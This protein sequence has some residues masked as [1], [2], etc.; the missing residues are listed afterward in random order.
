[1]NAQ[2]YYDFL[3][4][5][6]GTMNPHYMVVLHQVP[7]ISAQDAISY[8][9]TRWPTARPEDHLITSDKI[10]AGLLATNLLPEM[11]MLLYK[12]E[13]MLEKARAEADRICKEIEEQPNDLLGKVK[14][15]VLREEL[16]RQTGES[17]A[18]HDVWQM[19]HSRKYELMRLSKGGAV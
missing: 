19:L 3:R 5:I 14:R 15:S 18:L 1:M 8:V 9:M 2:S 12:I 11:E 4:S 6:D 13:D 16:T 10:Q 7:F 17:S